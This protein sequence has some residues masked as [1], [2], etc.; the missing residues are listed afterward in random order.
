MQNKSRAD[1][2]EQKQK[3]RLTKQEKKEVWERLWQDKNSILEKLKNEKKGND[4][5]K[6]ITE[7][8]FHPIISPGSRRINEIAYDNNVYN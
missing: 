3:A 5:H 6:F 4:I 7:C 8:T 2:Y 1:S